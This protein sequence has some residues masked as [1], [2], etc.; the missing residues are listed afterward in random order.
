MRELPW[1]T[2]KKL[3]Q[4]LQPEDMERGF[5]LGVFGRAAR[6]CPDFYT[7]CA[8]FLGH[9]TFEVA[10]MLQHLAALGK[11][12][13]PPQRSPLSQVIQ[14][15]MELGLEEGIMGRM[16]RDLHISVFPDPFLP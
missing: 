3:A 11:T 1:E 14:A 16:G 12:P 5:D 4:L 6:R 8:P 7:M 10:A 13:F 15:G 9:S 2:A